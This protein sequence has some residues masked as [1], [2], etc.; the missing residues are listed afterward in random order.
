M[1]HGA[2]RYAPVGLSFFDVVCLVLVERPVVA[3]LNG[4]SVAGLRFPRLAARAV[5]LRG[6]PPI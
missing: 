5:V 6:L 2:N 1:P 4:S 3:E